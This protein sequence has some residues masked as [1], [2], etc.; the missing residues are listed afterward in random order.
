[1]AILKIPPIRDRQ[2][3]LGLLIDHLLGQ[4]NK[5]NTDQPGFEH[6]KLSATARNI[7]INHHW[8]GN[9]RELQNTLQRAAVWSTG[10]TIDK[11][12][13]EE[14]ILRLPSADEAIL[15]RPLGN[16]FDVGSVIRE[17]ERHYLERAMEEGQGVKSKAAELLGLGSYQTVTDWLKRHGMA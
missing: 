7:L 4:I 16:G 17:V 8:P 13:A 5:Q 11:R 2:G 12:D 6:K 1:V 3:D 9:V 10:P 15:N 14:A